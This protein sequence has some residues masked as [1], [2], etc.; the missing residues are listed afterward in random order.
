MRDLLAIPTAPGILEELL[1]LYD[2][3]VREVKKTQHGV[4]SGNNS[5]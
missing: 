5:K 3:P 1:E 2:L 4:D